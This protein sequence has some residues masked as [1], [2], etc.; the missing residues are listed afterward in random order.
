MWDFLTHLLDTSDFVPRSNC[1]NWT[2]AHRLLHIL[3]DLG[4]WS[5][6]TAIPFVLIFF[7]VRRRNMPFSWM[8]GLFA[9]FIMACG[10]VHLI[11]AGMFFWPEY[12]LA[13]LVKLITAIV[14]WATVVALVPLVPKVLALRTPTEFEREIA[15]RKR[16]EAALRTSEALFRSAFDHAAFGVALVNAQGEYLRV[17][18]AFCDIVGRQPEELLGLSYE[19]ISHPEDIPQDRENLRR[20]VAGEIEF[21]HLEKRYLH[22]DG[23]TVWVLLSRSRV[24]DEPAGPISLVSQ[25]QDITARKRAEEAQAMHARQLNEKNQQLIAAEHWKNEFFSQVSHELRTPLTLILAPLETLLADDHGQISPQTRKLLTTAHGNASRLLQLVNGLLDLSRL[26]ADQAETNR[27]PVAVADL[28]AAILQDFQPLIQQRQLISELS[29]NLADEAVLMDRYLFERIFFN[30]LSNAVKFTPPGGRI[31]VFLTTGGGRLH[32]TVRDTGVGIAAEDLPRLFQKYQQLGGGAARRF[33]GTG[34]GL[35]LVKEFAELLGGNVAVEST[36]G[37]GTSF[38]VDMDAAACPLALVAT[39]LSARSPRPIPLY[40]PL[41]VDEIGDLA[42]ATDLAPEGELPLVLIAE[43][44]A[45]LAAYIQSLLADTCRTAIVRDGEEAVE[46]ARAW[47]PDL[48]LSDVMMP[49]RD[50]LSLCRQLKSDP[51]TASILVVLLTAMTH[52]DALLKGWE[53]GADEY[54][55]KPFHPRELVTRVRSL[56]AASTSRRRADQFEVERRSLIESLEQRIRLEEGLQSAKE[57]AE[58]ANRAKS[59]FLANM[60]HEIRTPMNAILALTDLLLTTDLNREQREYLQTTKSSADALVRLVNDILDF[61]KIEAGKLD[62]Q[63]REFH[64]RQSL[65]ETFLAVAVQAQQKGLELAYAIEPEIPDELIGDPGRIRQVLVNL[66]GNAVKFTEEGEVIVRV[67]QE[68]VTDRAIVLHFQVR[69]TGIGIPPEKQVM[70]FQAFTQ[71]DTTASRPYGGTGLGLTIAA[72]LVELMGGRIWIE[73]TPGV[74]ST[75]HFTA[76]LGLSTPLAVGEPPPESLAGR[77]ALVVDDSAANRAILGRMLDQWKV[78]STAVEGAE[79]AIDE[80]HRATAAGQ[81]YDFVLLDAV[82]PSV[83]GFELARRISA[84][85]A[86]P[87]PRVVMLSSASRS[88][89]WAECDE[90]GIACYLLKPVRSA[91]LLDALLTGQQ[92]SQA[93][94]TARLQPMAATPSLNILLAEDTPANQ[95]VACRVL[96]KQGH[97]IVVARDGAE[98]ITIWRQQPFDLILMDVQM[99]NVD[100]LAATRQIRAAEKAEH[101]H[102][103]PIVALTAHALKGDRERCLDAGMDAYLSKPID[104]RQLLQVLAA[105]PAAARLGIAAGGSPS[106]AAANGVDATSAGESAAA[107]STDGAHAAPAVQPFNRAAMLARLD[108]DEELLDKLVGFYRQ[109][110]PE[111][112]AKTRQ[113]VLDR[114]AKNLG[115]AAHRLAGVMRNFSAHAEAELALKL[116]TLAQEND[117]DEAL[118][119]LPG[120]ERAVLALS[121]AIDAAWPQQPSATPPSAK[122]P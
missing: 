7:L 95:L 96:E 9:T 55:F 75:F 69:D 20:L 106:P 33:E 45:E 51:A 18:R 43:D 49:T 79:P 31:E 57:A 58:A 32:L 5:A 17:N 48:L 101:R 116:E 117:F 47:H 73:S 115:F 113:A 78:R 102:R 99:P 59:E 118:A 68:S 105:L 24:S 23:H 76:Q 38:T 121:A 92:P 19:A 15:E 16:V 77:K 103:I 104:P 62:L 52:R 81:P 70:I 39:G 26:Q 42:A 2:P 29:V 65:H 114:N 88:V 83:D 14:S 53:S 61:S 72:R 36:R 74:G 6:Y 63:C 122:S 94:N 67:D 50:G 109:D 46:K 56:L 66:V 1:G 30:L 97:R 100:G 107:G 37:K 120:V 8:L 41:P 84:D 98:A 13:G 28:T 112:L 82:M 25:V 44:N 3:S 119:Q 86:R 91:E 40:P 71:A 22:K 93:E 60:S 12:R 80:L 111:Y 27:E 4:I 34:L 87:R 11:E 54:L 108:G 10:T 90:L 89:D 21:Y 64:L 110:A 85:D 35:A